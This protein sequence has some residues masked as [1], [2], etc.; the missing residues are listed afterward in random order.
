M[1]TFQDLLRAKQVL[2]GRFLRAGLRGRVV[3]RGPALSIHAAVAN[4]GRN[5]HAVGIGKKIVD[6]QA[7]DQPC[8]RL[9]VAQKLAPSLL[10]PLYMLP[11]KVDGIAKVSAQLDAQELS[12]VLAALRAGPNKL[13]ALEMPRFKTSYE[14]DDL[15]MV[16]RKAGMTMAFDRQKADFSGITGR[17]PSELPFWIDE[18]RHRAIIEVM[19]DGTEA[20]AVTAISMR[21]SAIP[22]REP[23]PEPFRVDRPFLF[24]I[25]DDATGAVLFQGRI[26]NPK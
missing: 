23:E 3:G 26:S 20:A 17:P 2:S 15:A 25:V 10:P 4:A 18:I 16:F 14:A 8:V 5:V 24:Y 13:V 7:T 9:Y 11:D 21:A 1:P 6:G 19:E 22:Q 12:N